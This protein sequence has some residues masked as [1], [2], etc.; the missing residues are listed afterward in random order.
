MNN[1]KI[2]TKLGGSSLATGQMISSSILNVIADE[3]CKH[4]IVSAPGAFEKRKK[5]TDMLIEAC[6]LFEKGQ[7]LNQPISLVAE[8][9]KEISIDLDI[10][11]EGNKIIS[12]VLIEGINKNPYR[13]YI[14]SCG[15]RTQARLITCWLKK[16]GH[17]VRFIDPFDCIF[18]NKDQSL[19]HRKTNPAINR[20]CFGPWI[21][22]IPGF[23][24]RGH[25]DKVKTFPRDGSD[26]SGA[27]VAGAIKANLYNMGKDVDGFYVADP[28]CVDDPEI[29]SKLS[30][31]EARAL[32]YAGAKVMHQATIL[33]LVEN[34]VSVRIFNPNKEGNFGTLIK[35]IVKHEEKKILGIA[36]KSNFV[37]F[38]IEKLMMN[39]EIGFLRKILSI[40]EAL[41]VP[42]DHIPTGIDTVALIV[43]MDNYPKDNDVSYYNQMIRNRIEKLDYDKMEVNFDVAV[44]AIV[45]TEQASFFSSRITK[46]LSENN[47]WIYSQQILG[48]QIIISVYREF[49][50]KATQAI[51]NEF[52]PKSDEI[53]ICQTS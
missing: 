50:K 40:F 16:Q 37:M 26:I 32:A 34:G 45:C 23:Y 9:F 29:I 22:V 19:N 42:V 51:Y 2:V 3:D 5:V 21:F 8:I 24:G 49:L 46:I 52:F 27:I 18:F 33:P 1:E 48:N 11:I 7:S 13:D 6:D 44:L 41:K 47:I 36:G 10:E 53:K 38:K 28:N 35:P 20:M 15:E 14:L 4:I 25:D 12:E 31:S 30:F 17:K 39:E 43:D